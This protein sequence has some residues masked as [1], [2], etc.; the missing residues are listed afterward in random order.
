MTIE[1]LFTLTQTALAALMFIQARRNAK[2]ARANLESLKENHRLLSAI[3]KDG[4]D[5]ARIARENARIAA[6]LSRAAEALVIGDV[7]AAN[8]LLE[9]ELGL[10][11]IPTGS[12]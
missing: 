7:A 8:E 10:P 4:H 6:V 9:R 12:A 11:H 1:I 5:N 2:Q 3:V